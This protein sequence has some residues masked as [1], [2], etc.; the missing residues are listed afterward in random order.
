ML[1]GAPAR[2]I[3]QATADLDRLAHTWLD[4]QGTRKALAQRELPDEIIE[5]FDKMEKRVSYLLSKAL[6]KHPLWSWIKQFP[7]LGGA[8]TALI[9]GRI[10]DPRRFPGQ[11][12]SK[13]HYLPSIYK[14]GSPCPVTESWCVIE[15]STGGGV[16]LGAAGRCRE[17]ADVL[18][19]SDLAGA[20]V[21]H[22]ENGNSTGCP[23]IMLEPRP[24]S[25][26]R[27]LW[28]WAGLAVCADGR[29]PRK[30]KG[31]KCDWEPQARASTMQ[32]G[33]LAEQ[34]VRSSVPHYSD[35]Y[36]ETKE[37]LMLR[38]AEKLSE[39]DSS[40]GDATLSL[41]IKTL[42]IEEADGQTDLGEVGDWREIEPVIGRPL[43]LYEADRIARKV[44]A[45]AFLGDLLVE[46][47][48]LTAE[49]QPRDR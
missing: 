46:W 21:S 6:R 30:R 2:H 16:A 24:H 7:G 38:V 22:S 8:H 13:G 3:D 18:G 20:A 17:I 29:A 23:G 47:K 9:I 39:S 26:V 12:C 35:V 27:S 49:K 37:R 36:R 34:I 45:K 40:R 43:K 31:M 33:G 41:A 11:R 25:G 1:R 32:P 42:E 10:G 15:G 44:A 5:G 4:L 14:V 19:R 28:H 48:R